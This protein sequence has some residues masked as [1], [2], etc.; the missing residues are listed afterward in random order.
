MREKK[1]EASKDNAH[2]QDSTM[3]EAGS[4]EPTVGGM[5]KRKENEAKGGDRG[6]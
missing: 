3:L 4:G 6:T 5:I 2:L 1:V